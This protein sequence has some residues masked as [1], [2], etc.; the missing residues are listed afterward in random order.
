MD[1]AAAGTGRAAVWDGDGCHTAVFALGVEQLE[2]VL[3]VR[4]DAE[5]HTAFAKEGARDAEHT[6]CSLLAAEGILHSKLHGH[7]IGARTQRGLPTQEREQVW[8]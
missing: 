4:R 5:E 3:S 8:L 7:R 2:N 1:L 6:R